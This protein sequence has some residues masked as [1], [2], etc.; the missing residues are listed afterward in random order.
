MRPYVARGDVTGVD[1]RPAGGEQRQERGLRPLQTK[2][3]SYSPLVITSSRLLYQVLRGLMRSFS[4]DLPVNKSTEGRQIA[5]G[6][7]G[8]ALSEI[9]DRERKSVFAGS[10]V[11][12]LLYSQSG[13]RQNRS[14]HA[15]SSH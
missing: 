1:G 12:L 9:K 6:A 14:P 13:H 10:R 15:R 3:T 8:L 5:R 11:A 2:V 4:A 7:P